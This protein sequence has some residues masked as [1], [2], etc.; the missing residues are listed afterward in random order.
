[1]ADEEMMEWT[2]CGRL[3]GK[4][5]GWDQ[6]DTFAMTLYDF[7]PA[8]GTD[9]PSGTV[10]IHFEHGTVETYDDD[11]EVLKSVDLVN[12]IKALPITPL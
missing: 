6:P 1:M 10:C 2:V 5:S 7:E 11:G 4:A 3:I 12:A 8:P 9:L